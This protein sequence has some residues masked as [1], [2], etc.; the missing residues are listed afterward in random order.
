MSAG[1]LAG[2]RV[3][4]YTR[5]FPG[6]FAGFEPIVRAGVA[7]SSTALMDLDSLSAMRELK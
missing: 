5:G 2:V 7:R 6:A 3:I 1:P 4:E